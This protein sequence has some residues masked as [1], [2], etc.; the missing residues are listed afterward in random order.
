MR[1]S[2][3]EFQTSDS[4]NVGFKFVTGS[5]GS[6]WLKKK[7][8]GTTAYYWYVAAGLSLGR[9]AGPVS[10]SYSTKDMWNSGEVYMTNQFRGR[11]LAPSD[12]AGC[13]FIADMSVGVG[14]VAGSVTAM[15]V[16]VPPAELEAELGYDVIQ[17]QLDPVLS[18]VLDIVAE[19]GD[20]DVPDFMRE[21]AKAVIVIRGLANST[22]SASIS[23]TLGYLTLPGD[24]VGSTVAPEADLPASDDDMPMRFNSD[25]REEG[26]PIVLPG[27]ALFGFDKSDLKPEAVSV[28]QAAKTTLQRYPD[29]PLLIDG[30]TDSIGPDDYNRGLSKRRA[31]AVKK[32]LTD[33]RIPNAMYTRGLGKEDRV[34]SNRTPDGRRQ[35]RRVHITTMSSSWRP[36]G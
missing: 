9:N 5:Q 30:Y 27:D 20:F 16:G 36:T 13:C 31:E 22:G 29:K 28:L 3:W 25:G 15:L 19:S 4:K 11:E 1:K 24:G 10:F 33:Q 17:S 14:N 23:G 2:D 35:N 34:A 32:W 18:K 12:L 7:D 21:H 26:P 6:I 8:N